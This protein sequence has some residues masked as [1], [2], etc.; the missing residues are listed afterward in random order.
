MKSIT[1]KQPAHLSKYAKECL[2]ALVNSGLANTISLG[3]AFGLFHYYDYRP[4]H[5]VDAWWTD[6][7]TDAKKQ[8]VVAVLQSTL[9]KFGSVRVRTWG[10]LT[11]IELAQDGKTVFSFQIALRTQR[12]N[13][14]NGAGW[15]DVPLDSFEDLVATKMNA[16]VQRGA[17]R[18]FLDIFT[19]CQAKLINI[20][21][22]WK[23]WHKRQD[24]IGNEHDTAKACLAIETH[25]ERIVL[26]RPLDQITDDQERKNAE[27][28]R[29]WFHNSFLRVNDE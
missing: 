26:Q 18:D 3:G 10:D 7:V 15:I 12:L 20:E 5:D 17:P 22:C 9:E 27:R 13:E 29:E 19:I 1:P 21:D 28:L 2:E 24:L 14:L 4:T 25:L 6:D 16:L 23:L 11:S 8:T